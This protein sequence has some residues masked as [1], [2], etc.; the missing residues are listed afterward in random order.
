[1][2]TNTLVRLQW[3]PANK[4]EDGS[5]MPASEISHYVLVYGES[6]DAMNDS[7]RLEVAG[8]AAHNLESLDQ[9]DWVIGLKTVSI[10]GSESDVSNLINVSL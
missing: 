9:G 3:A 6:S 10:Y 4:Y 5:A 1:M 7:I 2:V 8:L